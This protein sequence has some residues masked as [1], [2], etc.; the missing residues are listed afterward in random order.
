[1]ELAMSLTDSMLSSERRKINK[2]QAMMSHLNRFVVGVF[3]PPPRNI[4]R[5][6]L[7][8]D[9]KLRNTR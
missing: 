9:D 1:M 2:G 4:R 3:N 5:K 7:A 8:K 6:D